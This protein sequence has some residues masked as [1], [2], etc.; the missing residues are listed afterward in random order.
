MLILVEYEK[1]FIT[2]GQGNGT[3]TQ[4]TDQPMAPQRRDEE[5][6]QPHASKN[7]IKVK[8]STLSSSGKCMQNKYCITKLT[9]HKQWEQH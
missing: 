4:T 7:T 3:I 2:S 5:H 6:K 8:Q 9:P 1:S